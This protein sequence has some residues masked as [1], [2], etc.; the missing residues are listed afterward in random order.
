MAR[1]YFGT[2]G[3]RGR[4]NG[5]ITAELAMKVGQ[6]AGSRLP[7]RRSSP[8]RR[9]RQ[10]HAPF[11]LHDRICDGRWL[12]FGRASTS[13]ARPG[14]DARGGDAHALDAL[15]PR[16]DDLRLAQSFE[17]NG[18]KLFG[19]DGFKLSDEIEAEIETLMDA[20][21]D[22]AFLARADLG[23]ARRI[24]ERARPL[25][26]IR[27]AHAA[28]QR[29]ARRPAHRRRLRERR[30]YKAA[31]EALWEL[32]AEVFSIGV[33]PDGFNINHRRRLDLAR[34]P[35][36]QSARDARRHRRRARR[37]RRPHDHHRRKGPCRRRRPNPGGRRESWQADGRLAEARHRRHRHVE[38]RPGA[39]SGRASA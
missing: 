16:R 5:K 29:V 24:D 38:S 27:Q 18:I 31:P 26:R 1:K 14:S 8:S 3:I 4:A 21:I 9:H 2:D 15:R 10:G 13:V 30:R 36:A 34:G 17:D 39:A 32:G 11:G 19:P 35:R 6:A 20:E 12:H 28:A 23:R 33:D 25:Y 22:A 7:A 37:R